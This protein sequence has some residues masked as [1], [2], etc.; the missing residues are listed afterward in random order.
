MSTNRMSRQTD[1]RG[2][3]IAN[4]FVILSAGVDPVVLAERNTL[5]QQEGYIVVSAK[6]RQEVETLSRAYC[7]DL[8]I[9][10]WSFGE[11]LDNLCAKIERVN[12]GCPVIAF[13]SNGAPRKQQGNPHAI[14]ELVSATLANESIARRCA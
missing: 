5:L 9:L 4:R 14:A 2:R 8:I 7:F 11:E 6:N 12:P 1:V 10:C 3:T 13:S